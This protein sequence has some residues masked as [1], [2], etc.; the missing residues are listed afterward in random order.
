VS[1]VGA[2]EWKMVIATASSSIAPIKIR[3]IAQLAS[4]YEWQ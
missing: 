1:I 4:M 2:Q 3:K